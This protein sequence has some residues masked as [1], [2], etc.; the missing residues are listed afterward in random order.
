MLPVPS[1][2]CKKA[3]GM[4]AKASSIFTIEPRRRKF[5]KPIKLT[6]PLPGNNPII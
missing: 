4:K 6:I 5:H 1:D 3:V 2:L